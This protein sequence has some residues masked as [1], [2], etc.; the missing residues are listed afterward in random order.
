MTLIVEVLVKCFELHSSHSISINFYARC[1]SRI[2]QPKRTKE[3]KRQ[4]K[5]KRKPFFWGRGMGCQG[6]LEKNTTSQTMVEF[7]E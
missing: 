3:K 4:K 1:A 6:F 7:I 2:H 5:E